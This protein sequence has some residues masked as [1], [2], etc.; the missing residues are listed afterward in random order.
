MTESYKIFFKRSVQKDLAKLPPQE[1]QKILL[2]VEAL[3]T[4]PRPPD[5]IKLSGHDLYRIRQGRYRIVYS[6]E[7]GILQVWVIKIAH[8]KDVYRL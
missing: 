8:R 5:I 6:I 2:R 7:D 3:A 1:L 4:C